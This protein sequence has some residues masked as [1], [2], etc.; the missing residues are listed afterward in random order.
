MRVKGQIIRKKWCR[1]YFQFC[2]RRFNFGEVRLKLGKILEDAGVSFQTYDPHHMVVSRWG[3]RVILAP[4]LL[5]RAKIS[6]CLTDPYSPRVASR[7]SFPLSP[8]RLP[9]LRERIPSPFMV[10]TSSHDFTSI[11]FPKRLNVFSSNSERTSDR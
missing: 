9:S 3:A 10:V 5:A 8:H 4:D 11:H 6:C 1:G 7:C 2:L